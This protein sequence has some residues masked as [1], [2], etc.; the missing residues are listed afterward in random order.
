MYHE[1]VCIC[2]YIVYAHINCILLIYYLCYK[3][4]VIS[5]GRFKIVD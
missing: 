3:H 5:S 2:M 4:Y 1:R